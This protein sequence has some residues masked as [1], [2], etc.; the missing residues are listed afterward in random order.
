MLIYI[1]QNVQEFTLTIVKQRIIDIYI[2]TWQSEISNSRR[3]ITYSRFK[4]DFKQEN[5]LAEIKERKYK[6]ALTRFRT[7]SHT[8]EIER[9]RYN[10]IEPENRFCIFCTNRHIE[11]EYHFLLICPIYSELRRMYLKP[12]F[13]RWPTLNKFDKLMSSENK[14]EVLNLSKFIY[15]AN[16]LRNKLETTNNVN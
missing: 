5:Y 9:G 13:S 6:I 12:H 3:L 8:L 16:V 11:N 1:N 10:N 2:Q 14:K 7:S 15:H 4:R